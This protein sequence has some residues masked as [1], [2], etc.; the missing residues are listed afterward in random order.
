M[1]HTYTKE[2]RNLHT[3]P[4]FTYVIELDLLSYEVNLNEK[5]PKHDL[6]LSKLK[7]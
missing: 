4:C 3:N 2:I 6:N 5:Q 1:T 7:H